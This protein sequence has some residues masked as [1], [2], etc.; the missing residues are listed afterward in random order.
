MHPWYP[1]TARCTLPCAS[2]PANW[3]HHLCQQAIKERMS[4]S[5]ERCAS[6]IPVPMQAWDG[7]AACPGEIAC[8]GPSLPRWAQHKAPLPPHQ[9]LKQ[10][11]QTH[12]PLPTTEQLG[13]P[14]HPC[15]PPKHRH[16]SGEG[17]QDPSVPCTGVLP[18]HDTHRHG[19][20]PSYE[21]HHAFGGYQQVGRPCDRT[22]RIT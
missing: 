15:S 3:Q 9:G 10:T 2:G 7:F 14:A 16:R 20:A 18:S 11:R 6:A 13:V 12:N 4:R 1:S 19:S 21:C 22:A 8:P 5:V 17:E